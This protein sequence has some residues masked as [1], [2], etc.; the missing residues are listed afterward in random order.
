MNSYQHPNAYFETSFASH[1]AGQ[2]GQPVA[3]S[4]YE[5]VPFEPKVVFQPVSHQ[6]GAPSGYGIDL[7][8]PQEESP[9]G[10][11]QSDVRSVVMQLPQGV[12]I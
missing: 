1:I 9:N 4:G 12:A 7:E 3:V 10:V 5:Q 6:A 8:L 2:P 11:S